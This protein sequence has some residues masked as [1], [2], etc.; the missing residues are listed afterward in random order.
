MPNLRR[1][2]LAVLLLPAVAA[3]APADRLDTGL[4]GL[5]G[6]N[7]DAALRVFGE[8]TSQRELADHTVYTWV[9]YGDTTT[10]SRDDCGDRYGGGLANGCAASFA[11]PRTLTCTVRITT[12]RQGT[13]TDAGRNGSSRT[14][15]PFLRRFAPAK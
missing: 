9:V 14:C 4:D 3:C 12:N 7:R 11:T 8:P 13:I 10:L 1:L 5:K 2:M 15:A 6:Q